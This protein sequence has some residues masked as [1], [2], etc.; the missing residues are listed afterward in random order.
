MALG[1]EVYHQG[2]ALRV[3]RLKSFLVLFLCF[4][5]VVQD[6]SVLDPMSADFCFL[7]AIMDFSLLELLAPINSSIHCLGH[8]VLSQQQK[9]N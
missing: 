8:G 3:Q 4:I 7:P 1:E 6:L 2:K 9:S 5:H